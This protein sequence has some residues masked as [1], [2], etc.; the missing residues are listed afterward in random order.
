MGNFLQ[1]SL[2]KQSEFSLKISFR[3]EFY[4]FTQYARMRGG[5]G[6]MLIR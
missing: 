1:I 2:L 5:T 3:G 6:G 4:N